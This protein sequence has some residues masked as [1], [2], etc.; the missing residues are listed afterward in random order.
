MFHDLEVTELDPTAAASA[1][2]K[3]HSARWRSLHSAADA[4]IMEL[5]TMSSPVTTRMTF[6]AVIDLHNWAMSWC[7]QLG[8]PVNCTAAAYADGLTP[9]IHSVQCSHSGDG[10][11]VVD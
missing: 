2:A 3:V 9:R 4:M 6:A 8:E 5:G 11:D 10:D 1:N 7:D